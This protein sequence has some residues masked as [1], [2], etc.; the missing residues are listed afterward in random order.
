MC[1]QTFSL[2]L[3]RA[4]AA[5]AGYVK[6]GIP[7]SRK[8]GLVNTL[9]R[10]GLLVFVCWSLNMAAGP[11]ERHRLARTAFRTSVRATL[12]T[13]NNT[14]DFCSTRGRNSSPHLT[15]KWIL[16]GQSHQRNFLCEKR[17]KSHIFL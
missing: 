4:N 13:W 8:H 3:A 14:N 7:C 5:A 10:N 11:L 1:T 17:K 6:L 12:A 15:R 2:D 9:I 16:V